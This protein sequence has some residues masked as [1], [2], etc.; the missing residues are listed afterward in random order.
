MIEESQFKTESRRTAGLSL[1]TP[2]RARLIYD[3]W[4]VTA[5]AEN[6]RQLSDK[7]DTW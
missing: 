6:D 1:T 4:H 2:H 5:G 7:L 3:V